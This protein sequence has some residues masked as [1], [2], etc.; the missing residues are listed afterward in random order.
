[1]IVVLEG[2]SQLLQRSLACAHLPP[3]RAVQDW[4]ELERAAP[5]ALC[6][7]VLIDWLDQGGDAESLRHFRLRVPAHPVVLV[8]RGCMDNARHL[9]NAPVDEV[10]WLAE[11]ETVLAAAV[12]R[13]MTSGSRRGVAEAVARAAHL[14]RSLRE[15]LVHACT[16]PRPVY[17]VSELAGRVHCDRTTLCM[18]WR[19][20]V[21]PSSPLR[22]VDFLALVMLVHATHLKLLGRKTPQIAVELGVHEHTLRR[23]TRRLAG[24]A[25]RPSPEQ[26]QVKLTA[27][28]EDFIHTCLRRASPPHVSADAPVLALSAAPAAAN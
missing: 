21:G 23:L 12:H 10:V 22:L 3:R 15:A 7:V 16:A 20:A 5:A 19:K 11:V 17:S 27:A 4:R 26:M 1:M 25:A 2:S 9:L 28:L 18:Q 24:G 6:S 13:A 14:P 8:T